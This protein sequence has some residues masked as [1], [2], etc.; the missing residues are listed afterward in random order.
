MRKDNPF[1]WIFECDEAVTR[2]R[3]ALTTAPILAAPRLGQPFLIERDSSS[4][5]VAGVLKQEQDDTVRVIAYA[6]RTL[7]KHEA[8]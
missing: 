8:R 7:N 3:T 6:S 4:K 2:M 1:K 5:G